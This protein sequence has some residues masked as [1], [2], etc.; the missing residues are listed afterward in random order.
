MSTLSDIEDAVMAL[1]VEEQQAFLE[2][3]SGRLR[4]S[5]PVESRRGLKAAAYPAIKGLP[6]DLSVRVKERMRELVAKRHA[7]DR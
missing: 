6:P 1:P 5:P 7:A 3:L 2:L 4:Q